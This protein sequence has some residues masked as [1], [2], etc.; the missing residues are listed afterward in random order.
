MQK[1][2]RKYLLLAA[3]FIVIAMTA[4]SQSLLFSIYTT[5]ADNVITYGSVKVQVIENT[6]DAEGNEIPLTTFA[7]TDLGS[8]SAPDRIV[9]A[10]NTGDHPIYVRA[11]LRMNGTRSDGSEFELTNDY[12]DYAINHNDWT[13]ES[14]GWYYYRD[15]LNPGMTSEELMTQVIFNIEKLAQDYSC[16][17]LTLKIYISAVQSEEN[18]TNVFDAEGWPGEEDFE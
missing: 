15:A 5:T 10:K 12:V 2:Y 14:D 16:S 1:Q 18:S 8:N 7:I 17:D 3:L 11:M 13:L 6:L 4:V 9:Y